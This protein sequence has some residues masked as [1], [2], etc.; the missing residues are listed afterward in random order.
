MQYINSASFWT[1]STFKNAHK[2]FKSNKTRLKYCNKSP[3][4]RLFQTPPA[5]CFGS[6]PHFR[7]QGRRLLVHFHTMGHP[8]KL[9]SSQV[10]VIHWCLYE[11]HALGFVS[12]AASPHLYPSLCCL[13]EAL[14]NQT[15]D[16]LKV[17]MCVTQTGGAG[18][19]GQ[20]T[21]RTLSTCMLVRIGVS[22]FSISRDEV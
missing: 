17:P 19:R 15:L 6:S 3:G 8:E 12:N 11:G 7:K 4:E 16:T 5:L 22:V 10:V 20:I 18:F 2:S 21:N 13:Y 1:H 14:P 9:L